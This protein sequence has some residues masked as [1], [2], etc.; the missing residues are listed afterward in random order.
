MAGKKETFLS[1]QKI[2]TYYKGK[3]FSPF[4]PVNPKSTREQPVRYHKNEI[5]S[6]L[7]V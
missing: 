2:M 6:F 4:G 3:L 7:K 1:K 5:G